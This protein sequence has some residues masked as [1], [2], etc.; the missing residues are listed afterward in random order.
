MMSNCPNCKDELWKCQCVSDDKGAL[1]G[2]IP[3]SSHTENDGSQDKGE[4]VTSLGCTKPKLIGEFPIPIE[5][6]CSAC[7]FHEP[8]Q[9][10]EVCGGEVQYTKN[11]QVPWT[12]IKDIIRAA[13]GEQ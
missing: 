11:I 9:D 1:I 10:C 2:A 8:Q 3:P 6:T 4:L 5:Q 7:Y 12:T 13:L